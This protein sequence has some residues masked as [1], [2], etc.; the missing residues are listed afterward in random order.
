MVGPTENLAKTNSQKL[1]RQST[2]DKNTVFLEHGT[3]SQAFK[4]TKAIIRS[5]KPKE[6]KRSPAF[7]DANQ[8]MRPEKK[9]VD[10]P[11][12]L[13]PPIGSAL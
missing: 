3:Y 2:C 7:K 8:V 6:L 9:W 11:G 10:V 5:E 12:T 4:A 1:F 13:A